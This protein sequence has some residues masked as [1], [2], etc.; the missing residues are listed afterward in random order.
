[1]GKL[2]LNIEVVR[3]AFSTTQGEAEVIVNGRSIARYGDDRYLND[4]GLWVSKRS[5]LELVEAALRQYSN[6]IVS[7]IK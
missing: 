7:T 3:H 2:T 6:V 1:M 5:D 4:D